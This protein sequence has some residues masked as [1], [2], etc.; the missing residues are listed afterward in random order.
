MNLA[1]LESYV[2]SKDI[3]CMYVYTPPQLWYIEETH[4]NL[5]SRSATFHEE[6]QKQRGGIRMHIKAERKNKEND[7]SE[8]REKT[9]EQRNTWLR[10]A[11][12]TI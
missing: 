10:E 6:M 8:G 1:F 12:A 5:E 2:Y 3:W 4:V 11:L 9:K 7:M